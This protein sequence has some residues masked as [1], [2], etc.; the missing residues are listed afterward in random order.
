MT[1]SNKLFTPQL[2]LIKKHIKDLSFENPQSVALTN[3]EKSAENINIDFSV[4]LRPFD[5]IHVEV[6]L[7]IK[8]KCSHENKILFCLELDYL[9]FFKKIDNLDI[10]DDTITKEAV[11]HLFP[12]AKSI[13]HDISRNG[14]FVTIL[15]NELDL[16]SMIKN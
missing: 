9:G 12:S 13:I 4:I 2:H 3:I 7:Q 10:D 14:G 15:L 11:K 5:K 16:N 8:C 6:I 1:K